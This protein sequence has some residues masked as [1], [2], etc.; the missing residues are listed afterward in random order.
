MG[1]ASALTTSLTGLNAAETTIDVVGNNVANANTV[2]FKASAAAF[3]TQIYV[4]HSLGSGPTAANGGTNPRQTGLGTKV[5]AITPDFTQG[6]IEL[7][8]SPSDLA[9]EG[10]GFF[11]VE[12][13]QGEQLFTRNGIF[14]LNAS[15]E[16]VTINGQRLLGF[17]VDARFQIDPTTLVPLAIPLGSTMVAQATQNVFFQGTLRPNGDLADMAQIIQSGVLGDA[18]LPAPASGGNAPAAVAGPAGVPPAALVAGGGALDA[19]S[20]QYRVAFIDADGN[21]SF[22]SPPST[23]VVA[24]A[25]DRI[26]VTLPAAPAGPP[27]DWAGRRIYR[28]FNGG[29]FLRLTDIGDIAATGNYVDD[30]SQASIAGNPVLFAPSQ[31]G[32]RTYN[33]RVTYS[34]S[35][36]TVEPSRPS[37]LMGPI[38]VTGDTRVRLTGLPGVI[39]P[40]YDQINVYRSLATDD[41]EYHL[42]T[43]LTGG[44]TTYIDGLPDADLALNPLLDF[45]GPKVNASSTTL[46][47]ILVRTGTDTYEPLFAEAGTLSF[48]PEKGGRQ[49]AT[50]QLAIDG[51][52]TLQTLI[53]FMEQAMGIQ[54]NTDPL[55]PIPQSQRTGGLPPIDPGGTVTS[56][57]IQLVGNNGVNNAIDIALSGMQFVGNS[58]T[59]YGVNLPFGTVQDA[60]GESAVAD[61]IAYDS[62]G[63]PV[64]VRV[65]AVQESRGTNQTTYR[66]FADSGDNQT[67]TSD[68]SIAVGTGLITFDGEGKVVSVTNATVSILRNGVASIS[69]LDFELDFS[70]LSGL[71]TPTSTLAAARQDGSAPGTLSSYIIGED[72][73]IRGVFSNGVT[74]DLGQVRMARF[75]NNAGL[76][77]RGGNLYAAGVNS[78][79]PIVGNPNEQGI[80]R[81]VAGA[82]ELSNTDIGANLIDLILAST[83]YRGSARV[84]ETAQSLFDE[85]L[86]LRR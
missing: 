12:G 77:Q 20:Y 35:L 25:G 27:G 70:E 17:G 81:L 29:S 9:I 7:S 23:A 8:S 86:N 58:G 56:G 33:Y 78:G 59:V 30:A 4:T 19:G 3:A 60:V 21:E 85:I 52:T 1:L 53:N 63:I 51:T 68:V 45:D 36:S 41:T 14:K 83:Q 67:G 38:T 16:L 6:S 61:F 73:V 28:A 71:A 79:L 72:G 62:L 55:N 48:T 57:R 66:W 32:S 44:Q 74:R 5:A 2:G 39:P 69:P 31:T 18:S 82:L 24:A 43:T 22:P 54:E 75:A 64:T 37:P 10:D 47:N 84:I 50:K 49:L 40:P 65:T 11:I 15:N 13:S 34:N 76:D 80:G 42:V 46:M 26:D